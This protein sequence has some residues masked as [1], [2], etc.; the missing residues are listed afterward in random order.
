MKTKAMKALQDLANSMRQP[1]QEYW[2][3]HNSDGSLERARPAQ[4]V[5]KDNS[6][7]LVVGFLSEVDAYGFTICLFE[8]VE[9]DALPP[10]ARPRAP[11]AGKAK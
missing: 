11:V 4:F 5:R 7:D 2:M 9:Y 3:P 8:A 10:L 1:V 6:S